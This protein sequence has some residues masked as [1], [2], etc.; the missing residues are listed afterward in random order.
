MR[1]DTLFWVIFF[2]VMAIPLSLITPIPF[3]VA[4]NAYLSTG[5]LT[6]AGERLFNRVSGS[7]LQHQIDRE[8]KVE[9]PRA[10]T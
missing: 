4:F 8:A 2:A 10:D 7:E 5:F 3:W 1:R 6:L 9:T